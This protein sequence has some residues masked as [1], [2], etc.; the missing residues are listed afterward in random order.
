MPHPPFYYQ[1]IA[2]IDQDRL[3][4]EWLRQPQM[5]I[6]ISLELAEARNELESAKNQISVT[7]AELDKAIRM[8]PLHHG[9][10]K[11]TEGAIKAAITTHSKMKKAHAT[12]LEAKY[13]VDMMVAAQIALE[14]RKEALKHLTTLFL[15]EYYGMG[16]GNVS[17][18][19]ARK[20]RESQ[21]AEVRSKGQT[22]DVPTGKRKKQQ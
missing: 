5:Y 15:N 11:V 7:E 10:E 18:E 16:T 20:I 12:F 3:D 19:E 21:L 13:E 6:N 9:I 17:A 22:S 4:Y 14:H 1:Q 2:E 8:D